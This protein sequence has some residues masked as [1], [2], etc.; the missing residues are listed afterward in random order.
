MKITSITN[1]ITKPLSGDENMPTNEDQQKNRRDFLK[2]LGLG[3]ALIAAGTS[4][5]RSAS[6][7]WGSMTLTAALKNGVTTP[8]SGVCSAI[9]TCPCRCT[10]V[11]SCYCIPFGTPEATITYNDSSSG[12]I[13]GSN[14]GAM[15]G[16][17]NLGDAQ[18]LVAQQTSSTNVRV[19]GTVPYAYTYYE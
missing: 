7:S 18:A 8:S 5:P 14:I 12:M 13:S 10:C 11:C 2:K 16:S 3:G 4:F 15:K 17:G 6:A 1:R 9:C 19:T